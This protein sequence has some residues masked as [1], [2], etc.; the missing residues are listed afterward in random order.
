M[1]YK[2]FTVTY[3]GVVQVVCKRSIIYLKIPTLDL[4]LP[5]PVF[6]SLFC[7][8]GLGIGLVL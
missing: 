7:P 2:Y 1:V 3:L 4:V 5:L 6:L 8:M